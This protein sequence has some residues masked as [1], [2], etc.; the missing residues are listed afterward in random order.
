L[1]EIVV[2]GGLTTAILN[3]VFAEKLPG[4]GSVFIHVDWR[5]LAPARPGDIITGRVEVTDVRE[6]KPI[7]SLATRVTRQDGI[8]LVDGTAV[9]YVAKIRYWLPLVKGRVRRRSDLE[10]RRPG[11]LQRCP[12]VSVSLTMHRQTDLRALV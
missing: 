12:A 1:G 8:V 3:A 11:W 9:C 4:P 7:V 2:Q 10:P 6:D 5:Y